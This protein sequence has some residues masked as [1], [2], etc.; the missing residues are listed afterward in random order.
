VTRAEKLNAALNVAVIVGALLYVALPGGPVAARVGAWK[1][2]RALSL[3]TTEAWPSIVEVAMVIEGA[4]GDEMVVEVGDYYCP[5]CR[6]AEDSIAL[7]H[8]QG[9]SVGFLHF[10]LP[11]HPHADLAARIAICGSRLGVGPEAHRRLMA[12]PVRTAPD[13]TELAEALR[14]SPDLLAEC[15]E[16]RETQRTLER[17]VALARHIGIWATPTF[18]SRQDRIVGVESVQA[19]V[20]LGDTDGKTQR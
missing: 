8:R 14:L 19:L 12:G 6:Q 16:D 13:V 3:A 7:V 18:L 1:E 5:A 17:H 20:K 4:G 2:Q 10:P 15:V 11:V 9:R